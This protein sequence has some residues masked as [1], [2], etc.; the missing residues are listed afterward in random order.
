MHK[1]SLRSRV[2]CFSYHAN[3]F[4]T[5]LIGAIRIPALSLNG[6]SNRQI[7]IHRKTRNPVTRE[8]R[9][10]PTKRRLRR[11][12]QHRIKVQRIC[13]PPP[14]QKRA[15]KTASL[16]EKIKPERL[17]NLH[18]PKVLARQGQNYE[19]HGYGMVFGYAEGTVQ[20]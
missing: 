8:S 14:S 11:T 15:P 6:Q 12:S 7:R 17:A 5:L 10:E 13:T 16:N 19:G 20:D 3:N 1:A 4:M 18:P 9:L 2:D